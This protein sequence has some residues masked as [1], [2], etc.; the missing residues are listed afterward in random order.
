MTD[1]VTIDNWPHH[2]LYERPTFWGEVRGYIVTGNCYSIELAGGGRVQGYARCWTDCQLQMSGSP[3]GATN[4]WVD[5]SKIASI[6]AV[7]SDK[8]EH[9]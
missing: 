3:K 4:T 9:A 2:M 8:D 6:R 5:P 7:Q 1:R